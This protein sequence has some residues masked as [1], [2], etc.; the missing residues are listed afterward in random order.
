MKDIS[1]EIVAYKYKTPEKYILNWKDNIQKICKDE[2]RIQKQAEIVYHTMTKKRNMWIVFVA[3][4]D[5]AVKLTNAINKFWMSAESCTWGKKIN[6]SLDALQ[7][8][9]D[10]KWVV[11][12]THQT[13]WTEFDCPKID[14]C[15]YF[16]PIE[17]DGIIQKTVLKILRECETKSYPLLIDWI[18]SALSSQTINRYKLYSSFFWKTPLDYNTFMEFKYLADDLR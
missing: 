13:I 2:D 9:K 3:E 8:N 1:P 7:K 5:V 15:F 14:T 11:V 12:V 18:D 16:C 6:N 17:F 4:D 10:N